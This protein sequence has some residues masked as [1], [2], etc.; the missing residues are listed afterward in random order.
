MKKY[1]AALLVLAMLVLGACETVSPVDEA[2]TGETTTITLTAPMKPIQGGEMLYTFQSSK[3][4]SH[5]VG[6]I[7]ANGKL[8]AKPQY[9]KADY[10]RDDNGRI[11]GLLAQHNGKVT[12]YNLDGSIRTS[13]DGYV[14]VG[15]PERWQGGQCFVINKV[16]YEAE[17]TLCEGLYDL[18]ANKF[19]YEMKKG[20]SFIFIF[21][22]TK[23]SYVLI[24]HNNAQYLFNPVDGSSQELPNKLGRFEHYDPVLGFYEVHKDDNVTHYDLNFNSIEPFEKWMEERTP[25]YRFQCNEAG[26]DYS[27]SKSDGTI[28]PEKYSFV[29]GFGELFITGTPEEQNRLLLDQNLKVLETEENGRLFVPV[30]NLTDESGYPDYFL[31]VLGENGQ[32]KK[33]Y[34]P[35]GKEFTKN[36]TWVAY[37]AAKYRLWKQTYGVDIVFQH[38]NGQW[39]AVD[40]ALFRPDYVDVDGEHPLES[41]IAEPYVVCDDY[42]LVWSGTRIL[43][44]TPEILS[45][46]FAVDWNGK[47]TD[48]APL[49]PY[50]KT[51]LPTLASAG[52]RAL[53]TAGEQG[54]N[55][56]WIEQDGKR[57]YVNT[58][59]QWLFVDETGL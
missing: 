43:G 42:V 45:E 38:K 44:D 6:L 22:E 1:I 11:T 26:D 47:R 39:K 10:I 29:E 55:Y 49:L 58:D 16:P 27:F 13:I 35:E 12:V 40:L 36:G 8:V 4:S 28:W 48:N 51:A 3:K 20:N 56:Y 59:G 18:K 15:N 33:A 19:L 14:A 21:A 7:D 9:E 23:K 50:C 31:I 46:L 30:T 34:T 54:P 2:T 24:T 41:T 53:P 5:Y 57:G 52:E 37:V 32:V 17:H 25:Q